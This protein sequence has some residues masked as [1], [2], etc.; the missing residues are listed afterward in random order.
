M[1]DAARDSRSTIVGI[2]VIADRPLTATQL[3]AL[4]APFGLTASNVKSHLSRMV[5]DG[6]LLRAGSTRKSTYQP[7]LGPS[8]AVESIDERVAP[9]RAEPW[10]SSWI[11]LLAGPVA[12]RTERDQI[13]AALWLDG[14]RPIAPGV[15]VRPAWPLPWAE[16]QARAYSEMTRGSCLRGKFLAFQYSVERLYELDRLDAVARRLAARLER[17]HSGRRGAV[18]ISPREAF[19]ARLRCGEDVVRLLHRDP[20]LPPQLWGARQ[21]L[22]QLV[23]AYTR[24]EERLAEPA[25]AFVRSIVEP[26]VA[27]A[28]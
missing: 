5:A 20:R 8:R 26:P 14:F 25:G 10:D 4:A 17:R 3:I 23:E 18:R 28:G 22:T 15:L 19:C 12:T 27:T 21:G 24:F 13:R 7:S 16:L 6:E 9:D 11:T 2:L 1:Q